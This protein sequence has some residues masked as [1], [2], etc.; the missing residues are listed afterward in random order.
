M[1]SVPVS[2]FSRIR[3]TLGVSFA[4]AA[5]G[6]VGSLCFVSG[7]QSPTDN[8]L[9]A[10]D[11]VAK[12]E[13]QILYQDWPKEADGTTVKKPDFVLLLT[14]QTY[15]YLQKCGCSNPQKGGLER[16]YNYVQSLK[17]KGWEVIGIDL[18]DV[19]R[20]LPYTPT[21]D[22]TLAKYETAMQAMKMM[23][24]MATTVGAE[25]L[26]N[27]LLDVLQKYSLQNGNEL[28][29]VHAANVKNRET[30]FPGANGSMLAEDDVVATKSG[31]NVGIIGVAGY[32]VIQKNPDRNVEFE[33]KTADVI[34]R[35]FKKWSA[36]NDPEIKVML[37]QGP[38]D[39]TDEARKIKVDAQSAAKAFPQF[40]I[41]VCQTDNDSEPPNMPTQVNDGRTM[42]V[43][44]G[45]R[46]QNVGLVGVYKGAKGLELYY[47]RVTMSDEFDTPE[48]DLKTSP[49]IKLLQDYADGVKDNDY[50]SE[51]AKRKK[52]H[53]V[54]ANPAGK[55]SKFVGNLACVQCH[56]QETFVWQ[57]SKHSHAYD[58]LEKIASR[59]SKRNFD[60]ECIVCHTV[61]Y[62]FQTG[63]VNS[64]V[65]P[66]L[67]NVQCESCH[68]PASLHVE[69]EENNLK[70][71]GPATHKTGA[72]LSPWRING[73]GQMPS[74][75]RLAA[76]FAEKAPSKREALASVAENEFMGRVFQGCFK[77]H[78]TDNDPKF[79]L[80]SYWKDIAHSGFVKRAPAAKA[81][82]PAKET[83]PVSKKR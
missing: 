42:I 6:I 36:K 5:V 58:A 46:G 49:I 50:L 57:K 25:E 38:F 10:A 81:A 15:G 61:G 43:R 11:P 12:T 40:Q 21:K 14:G 33:T 79:D 62:Q 73:E 24:Y 3:A 48:A 44:V 67:M 39:F 59:P 68:G 64:K 53:E 65:T 78:D 29:K 17:A 37:Y 4:M 27:S 20:P 56:Q 63:Y 55:G 2:S 70:S 18:G 72:L 28:P 22:Q 8:V 60:G 31:L 30:G 9:L 41:V 54:Q 23:G 71:K 76:M 82:P 45:Q 34:N 13:P 1:R 74:L 16:R 66:H 51:M 35:I 47:Q 26:K 75:D 19:L 32:E 77:C 52:L 83:K 7:P 69:E 80:A